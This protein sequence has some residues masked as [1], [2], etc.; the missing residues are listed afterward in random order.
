MKSWNNFQNA[1]PSD[2]ELCAHKRTGILHLSKVSIFSRIETN[3]PFILLFR[4]KSH[5]WHN[6]GPVA[7]ITRPNKS[8]RADTQLDL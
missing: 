1:L 3:I 2:F 5:F 7:T 6:S 4:E 8:C